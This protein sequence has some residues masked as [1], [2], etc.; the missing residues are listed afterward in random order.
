MAEETSAFAASLVH[1][2]GPICFDPQAGT[3]MP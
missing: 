1:S 3:L 2:I